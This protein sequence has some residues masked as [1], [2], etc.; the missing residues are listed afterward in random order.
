MIDWTVFTTV[1]SGVI[2]YVLGQ[3][4]VKLAIEP[5]QDLRKTIGQISHSMIHDAN[6][7]LN[8]G[9]PSPDKISLT[10]THLRQLSAQLESHLSLVPRYTVT[11]FVFRLPSR[12]CVLMASKSLIGLSNSLFRSSDRVYDQNAQ[13]METVCDSLN[14]Y[15]ADEER[16]SKVGLAGK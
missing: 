1:I 8:P 11:A 3:I 15:M 4:V 5:V 9:V 10:S 7:I 2:T 12:T 6:V 14:I 13:R 16:I